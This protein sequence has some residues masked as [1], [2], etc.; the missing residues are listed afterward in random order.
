MGKMTDRNAHLTL[1][2]PFVLDAP[3]PW[4]SPLAV[5]RNQDGRLEFF[6][7]DA[8]GNL[9]NNHQT[10]VGGNLAKWTLLEE[11]PGWQSVTAAT[12]Q[13]G[14]I[15]VFAVQSFLHA[16]VRRTQTAPNATTYTPGQPFDTAFATAAAVTDQW[17]G[18][19]VY[20]NLSSG[21]IFHRWQ[22]FIN[23]D[24]PATGWSTPWKQLSGAVTRM[25]VKTG[26]DG[27]GVMIG[28]TE[29]GS[30]F[31]RKMNSANA[32]TDEEWGDLFPLDGVL[33]SVDMALNLDGR[34]VIFGIDHD[35]RLL[36]R[37]ETAPHN[38]TFGPW[39]QVP[40][41][42]Q[43]RTLRLRFSAAERYLAGRLELCAVDESGTLMHA[44]QTAPNSTTWGSWGT[45][46]ITLRGT[47]TFGT[48]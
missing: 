35:G 20:A 39:Q 30:L 5:A 44:R 25:V 36:Q 43:D 26:S 7:A 8:A 38:A 24:T 17:G 4:G 12:N 40:T 2:A 13:D 45:L 28:V 47:Q 10:T 48:P 29:T 15:E 16:V 14:R 32:Q 1:P 33:S 27:R 9:W 6:G 3:T 31:Q 42:F 11:G 34:L 18:L 46:G 19:H 21:E 37:F 41:V 23:D 22:D